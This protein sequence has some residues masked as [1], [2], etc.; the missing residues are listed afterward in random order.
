MYRT[1]QAAMDSLEPFKAAARFTAGMM[2][3]AWPHQSWPQAAMMGL[4]TR[5]MP[6]SVA[7]ALELIAESGTTHSRPPFAIGSVTVGNRTIPIREEATFSTPFGTLLHFAKDLPPGQPPLKQPKI[8]VVAPMSGHFAT[9]LRGTV[10]V[11]LQDHDVY[12][13]DWHNARDIPLSDGVFGFD[14]YTDHII[15]FLEILGPG[16]Q[17]LA[18]CQPAVAVLV[19][20]AVMA[21]MNNRA[22]PRT[23]T[24]MAGPID[25][26]LNP[27]KVNKLANEKPIA[28]FKK[29]LIAS[30]P[31]GFPGA[32][33]RVY[34]GFVQLTAFMAM[35]LDRH[36]AAFRNQFDNLAK[37]D[38]AKAAAHRNFYEEY[39]AVMDLPAEFYI[40]TVQKVFQE[41]DLPLGKMTWHMRPVDPGAIRR[42]ALFTVEGELDDI[43]SIGQTMAALDLCKNLSPT[44]KRHHLQ[45][46]VGHYGV[47]N[48]RRWANEIYPLLREFIQSHA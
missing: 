6:A 15:R 29:N 1:Y 16:S 38:L 37:G 44:M 14:E 17:V 9:L 42:T 41:H 48:G 23:M 47:F 30:V 12:I 46:G 43:C 34:P 8:L 13:S 45:T 3:Q 33:R 25:T 35:N 24:L 11:L 27:T 31:A 40:E 19:S 7:A 5:G 22:Q 26:R 21:Q 20:V 32:H 39:F 10:K 28:W 2:R 4:D 36:K 18:V